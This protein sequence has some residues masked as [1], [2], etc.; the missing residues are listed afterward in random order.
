MKLLI[1]EKPSVALAIA[2]VVGIAGGKED[3]F[4]NCKDG[5]VC[6]W[7]FGH[8]LKLDSPESYTGGRVKIEDLPII[9]SV[10]KKS[11]KD[12]AGAKKQLKIIFGLLKKCDSVIHGGDPDREGQLLIDEILQEA[13]YVGRVERLWLSAVDPQSIKNALSNLRDNA[14][15]KNL[16]ISAELRSQADW[17]TGMNCSI[18]L[19]RKIQAAGGN[20]ALSIG[21]VQTPTLTL[22]TQRESDLNSFAKRLHYTV[23][24]TVSPNAIVAAWRIPGDLL[25][26]DLLLD[27]QAADACAAKIS[28]QPAVVSDFSKKIGQ[29]AAPMPFSLSALQKVASAKFGLSAAKTLKAAQNLYENGVTTY[30]RTD[31]Q[32]LPAEQFGAAGGILSALKMAGVTGVDGADAGLKHAC[33]DTSKIEAHHAIIP[34]GENLGGLSGDEEKLFSLIAEAYIRL[35]Y[36]AEKFENREA[37]FNIT[38]EVFI[39]KSKTII[40]PGWTRL[41]GGGSDD[42]ANDSEQ[43][44]MS[45]ALP[46]LT[47]GDKLTCESGEVIARETKPPKAFTD[48]SLIGAMSSVHS[49]VTDPRLKE[50]LK[51]T[52]GLG[53]EATRAGIIETLISRGY[54]ARDKKNI[55][56]TATGLALI[57]SVKSSCPSLTDPALTAIWEDALSAVAAGKL[58][59]KTFFDKQIE[60]VRKSTAALLSSDTSALGPA[61]SKFACPA[62]SKTT[63]SERKTKTGFQFFACTS[64]NKAFFVDSKNGGKPGAEL[65]PKS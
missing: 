63:L 4:V 43:N 64:C 32:Y 54:A 22:L 52:S 12:D 7:A 3:G 30:P 16:S 35:F 17:L 62:C 29:R 9:P 42:E 41:G 51:E 10:F 50:K 48:G 11:V 37:V 57:K 14:D 38:G 46:D 26:D 44:G 53:T 34:T 40:V 45:K 21:R 13:G 18:A 24:A 27:K 23:N 15:Y 5:L 59:G 33:W 25:T 2:K 31:C 56:A 58:D 39:A 19:S 61:P 65:K 8:L 28:R 1:A 55:R 36:E 47:P 60:S 6:T 49:L 20:A